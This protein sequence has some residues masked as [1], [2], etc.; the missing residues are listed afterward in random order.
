MAHMRIPTRFLLACLA[1]LVAVLLLPG[2]VAFTASRTPWAQSSP[3]PSSPASA[4]PTGGAIRLSPVEDPSFGLSAVVPTD[5]T[6]QGHGIYT[7][8]KSADDP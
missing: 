8:S 4:A 1:I 2:T 3:T 5:W 7:R 6:N